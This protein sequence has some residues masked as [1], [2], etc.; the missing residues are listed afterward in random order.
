MNLIDNP[1]KAI[2][3]ILIFWIVFLLFCVIIF[4]FLFGRK[5]GYDEGVRKNYT[6]ICG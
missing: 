5:V 3:Y 2:H 1:M 6:E 4:A